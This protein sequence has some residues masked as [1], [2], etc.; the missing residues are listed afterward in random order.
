M[1]SYEIIYTV[2]APDAATALSAAQY[3]VD[4]INAITT[5]QGSIVQQVQDSAKTFGDKPGVK[6]LTE[7]HRP[8][9]VDFREHFYNADA[10]W[11]EQQGL[12]VPGPE[13]TEI[14]DGEVA[15]FDG[16]GIRQK[17]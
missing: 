11:Y 17:Y 4:P 2:E 5:V 6:R 3:G 13:R 14:I 8:Q 7:P 9:A 16:F 10:A 12:P 1:P 15:H